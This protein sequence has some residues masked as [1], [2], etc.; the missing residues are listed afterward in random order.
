MSTFQNGQRVELLPGRE[1]VYDRAF[2]ASRGVVSGH[3]KDKHGY[4]L[5]YIIWDKDHW[6]YNGEDDL[7]TF[8]S[9]FRPIED[10]EERELIGPEAQEVP[11]APPADPEEFETMSEERQEQMDS[12]MDALQFAAEKASESGAFFFLCVKDD[13]RGHKGIEVLYGIGDPA[14]ENISIADVLGY[15]EREMRRRGQ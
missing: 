10:G 5:I 1:D 13:G 2:P 15:A 4:D 9:H 11:A 7:W 12:Y 6:R 3:R 8:A 14:L